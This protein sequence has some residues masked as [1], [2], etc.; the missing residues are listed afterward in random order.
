MTIVQRGASGSR[1]FLAVAA[2][3]AVLAASGAD[4]QTTLRFNRWLPPNHNVQGGV[5]GE[6]AK[7]VETVTQG[8][9]KVAFTASSLGPPPRQVD[10]A[11]QGVADLVLG[12]HGYTPARFR[13][14]QMVEMPFLGAT[15]EK[16]SGAYWEVHRSH[17][18]KANEHE[19]VTLLALWVHGP[20]LIAN[21]V[22]Q[23]TRIEDFDGLKLRVAGGLMT[24]IATSLG[25]VPIQAPVPQL[26]E[27]LSRGV[28]DGVLFTGEGVTGFNLEKV[29][30]HV[31]NVPGGLFNTSFFL[32]ANPRKWESL[33]AADRT[34]IEGLSGKALSMA[35]GRS[36][37]ERDAVADKD[38][39][40]AGIRLVTADAGFV[41]ALKSRLAP[42]EEAW[43]ADARTKGIDGKSAIERLRAL[44][45]R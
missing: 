27:I 35:A 5:M 17:L 11:A 25:A 37:D 41:A 39:R 44:A 1:A 4:A 30:K 24:E 31:T 6:W 10:L 40:A 36:Y 32:A 12:V 42:L 23:V 18:T 29:V 7:Q 38:L 26:Y 43:I 20:G 14:T 34:A 3:A 33:S 19:G 22:R 2:A 21:S 15:G 45:A 8:R 16:I 9:V 13:M 28:A